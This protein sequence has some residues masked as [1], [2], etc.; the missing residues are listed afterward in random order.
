M[1]KEK[2]ENSSLRTRRKKN[3]HVYC[4]LRTS[5]SFPIVCTEAASK[6]A[7]DSFIIFRQKTAIEEKHPSLDL[8]LQNYFGCDK[9]F[10]E[11]FCKN[12]LLK[13]ISK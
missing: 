6:W 7:P 12:Q 1:G 9:D 11:V 4:A 5:L 8:E 13:S 2:Q 10:E 3:L